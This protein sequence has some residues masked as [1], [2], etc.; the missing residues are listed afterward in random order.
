MSRWAGQA[1]AAALVAVLLAGTPA[2]ADADARPAAIEAPLPRG[3]RAIGQ[4]AH[5]SGLGFRDTVSFYE[6][7]FRS[8]GLAYEL[9]P[10]YSYRGTVVA[11]FVPRHA[12]PTATVAAPWAAIHIVRSQG[13]T[14][15]YILARDPLD[16][17][18]EPR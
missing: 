13:R 14:A 12:S 18:D 6:R 9:V 8:R 15:I 16:D 7:F 3:S 4:G 2:R 11:R 10:V 1:R 5:T 17:R